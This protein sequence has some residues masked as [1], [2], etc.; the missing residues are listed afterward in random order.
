MSSPLVAKVANV[1]PF[2]PQNTPREW[3]QK[4]QEQ[5]EGFQKYV[6]W[7]SDVINMEK[8]ILNVIRGYDREDADI[9]KENTPGKMYPLIDSYLKELTELGKAAGELSDP[10]WLLF[11]Y[12]TIYGY[13]NKSTHT[14]GDIR[15]VTFNLH[16]EGYR[17]LS[18]NGS[19]ILHSYNSYRNL[20]DGL[21]MMQNRTSKINMASF[22]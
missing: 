7:N 3:I 4:L 1:A 20:M 18:L 17:E 8:K 2:Y 5:Q 11:N 14:L 15:D 13:A 19:V 12:T 9:I 10:F 21:K 6:K 16:F 22:E